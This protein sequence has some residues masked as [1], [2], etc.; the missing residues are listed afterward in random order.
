MKPILPDHFPFT[1][2]LP[3]NLAAFYKALADLFEGQGSISPAFKDELDAVLQ[4]QQ[5]KRLCTILALGDIPDRVYYLV[6]GTTVIFVEINR[7]GIITQ[8]AWYIL[9]A[10]AFILPLHILSRKPSPVMIKLY[11]ESCLL[12]IPAKAYQQLVD[13]YPEAG[14]LSVRWNDRQKLIRLNDQARI[15][16]Y[17]TPFDKILWFMTK[18]PDCFTRFNST[19]I[20]DYTG[21]SRSTVADYHA[22]VLKAYMRGE[23]NL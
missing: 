7:D 3:A 21:L 8:Q 5:M 1:P 19:I 23:R 9:E 11:A 10:G 20:A 4:E 18:W 15:N 16:S 12:S 22:D 2:P 17:A 13:T 6:S 14:A